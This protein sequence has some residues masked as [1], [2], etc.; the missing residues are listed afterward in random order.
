MATTRTQPATSQPDPVTGGT[1]EAARLLNLE[2]QTWEQRGRILAS[3]LVNTHYYPPGFE[4]VRQIA[5]EA[6]AYHNLRPYPYWAFA[7]WKPEERG[8][9][10]RCL[11]LARR[12]VKKGAKWLFGRPVQIAIP[13]NKP[14]EEYF[15]DT[16]QRNRMPTRMVAGAERG[17]YQG[18]LALKWSYDETAENPLSFQLLSVIDQCRLYY[19]PHDSDRLLM[20][21]VQYPVFNPADGEY[22]LYRE[23]WTDAQEVHYQPVRAKFLQ[24]ARQGFPQFAYANVPVVS[25]SNTEPDL[26]EKW[27][28]TSA[29]PNR[30]GVIPL[31][32]IRNADIGDV[33]G[34]GDLWTD[35]GGGMFRLIDRLN[36]A[37][38]YMD[39]SNQFDSER[40][41]VFFDVDAGQDVVGRPLAPGQPLSLKSERL[42]DGT[43]AK[44]QVVEL[45][46][47]GQMRPHLME[48]AESLRQELL[49][50]AG[51]VDVRPDE[52]TNKGNLTSAVMSQ[53]YAPLIE[54][55]EE[56][57]KTY[58][59]DGVAKFLER[60]AVGLA[61]AGLTGRR[62]VPR[63]N[64]ADED[65]FD[66]QLKWPDFF[67]LPEDEKTARVTRIISEV[68]NA[69]M[70]PER[71]IEEVAKV[72]GIEDVDTM[73][74][75]LAEAQEMRAAQEQ[76]ALDA[77]TAKTELLHGEGSSLSA[78]RDLSVSANRP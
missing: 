44:G 35:V 50:T 33:W 8:T 4:V 11:P 49:D 23:E 48:Y 75:E 37:Y 52:I 17:G 22:W 70:P 27:E 38:Q 16:W 40:N 39:K 46:A 65:N 60:C 6:G 21:R 15:R 53:L 18:G 45:E 61:N 28:I 43:L 74:E 78:A 24:L 32:P 1:P 63:I 64:I 30:F 25:G 59:E 14:L 10:P 20:A 55:T 76:A 41:L 62:S 73:K 71:A 51:A 56:K 34:A 7:D 26:Y 67:A 36:L 66:V 29:R 57:R 31:H 9:L 54:T 58:G 68:D 47:S 5:Y 19:D 77:V 72:E 69:L 13:G 12:I 2:N 42:P 3:A